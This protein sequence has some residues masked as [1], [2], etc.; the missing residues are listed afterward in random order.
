MTEYDCFVKSFAYLAA[1]LPRTEF[2]EPFLDEAI[3]EPVK[4][5]SLKVAILKRAKDLQL[6]Q[7]IGSDFDENAVMAGIHQAVRRPSGT[8]Q[9]RNVPL[10]EAEPDMYPCLL[11]MCGSVFVF[12]KVSGACFHHFCRLGCHLYNYIKRG[13]LSVR[14]YTSVTLGVAS[15]VANDVIMISFIHHENSWISRGLR[16]P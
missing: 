11:A 13:N 2:L 7:A 16:A 9:E 1:R 8:D 10:S 12:F 5:A 3:A 4:R 6:T 14:T 15:S